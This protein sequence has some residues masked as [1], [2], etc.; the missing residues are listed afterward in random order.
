MALAGL[1]LKLHANSDVIYSLVID[2]DLRIESLDF[3]PKMKN[4]QILSIINNRWVRF[5]DMLLF[6]SLWIAYFSLT[7]SLDRLLL[8]PKLRILKLQGNRILTSQDCDAIM[9]LNKLEILT[10]SWNP[11]NK[12]EDDTVRFRS[13]LPALLKL[14]NVIQLDCQDRVETSDEDEDYQCRNDKKAYHL[15]MVTGRK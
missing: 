11:F 5:F 13:K 12:T 15:R 6:R 10:L 3:M 14:D 1:K 4:L 8:F 2:S 7:G 9:D